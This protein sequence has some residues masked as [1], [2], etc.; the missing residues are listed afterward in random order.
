MTETSANATRLPSDR[1]PKKGK[2]FIMGPKL[3]NYIEGVEITNIDRLQTARHLAMRPGEGGFPAFLEK[4]HLLHD[5][6]EGK[7]LRDF[8]S[9]AL[10]YQVVSERLKQVFE[11]VDPEGF[12]FAACDYTLADGSQ[13]PQ[14][15]LCDITHS[16]DAVDEQASKL[17]VETGDFVNGK[18]YNLSGAKLAFRPEVIGQRHVF[19]TPYSADYTFC[20]RTL[21]DAVLAAGKGPEGPIRGI[22][23]DDAAEL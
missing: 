9:V 5:P 21:R 20:D 13:G 16:L 15:Y 7:P 23:F 8:G 3:D 14:F 12:A 18:F 2:Y 4:P 19:E 10:G 6:K 11:A 17:V 1:A 22:S